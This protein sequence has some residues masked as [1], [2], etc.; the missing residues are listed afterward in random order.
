MDWKISNGLVAGK[1]IMSLKQ[2]EAE[3]TK[4]CGLN[5]K[6]IALLFIRTETWSEKEGSRMIWFRT[7]SPCARATNRMLANL[8]VLLSFFQVWALQL[9]TSCLYRM[10]QRIQGMTSSLVRAQTAVSHGS[11]GSRSWP[12]TVWL[13]LLV[14]SWQRMQRPAAMVRLLWHFLSAFPCRGLGGAIA[15]FW[16]VYNQIILLIKMEI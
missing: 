14:H 5:G 1:N 6:M 7:Q 11:C 10:R 8:P 15:R 16:I 2:E 3:L 9:S 4:V 12:M 13:L